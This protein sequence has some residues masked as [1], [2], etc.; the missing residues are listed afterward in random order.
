LGTAW[1]QVGAGLGMIL[2]QARGWGD[3][4]MILRWKLVPAPEYLMVTSMQADGR[5]RRS[6]SGAWYERSKRR[7][8]RYFRNHES[9]LVAEG[10]HRERTPSRVARERVP[11]DLCC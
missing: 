11:G 4:W 9:P 6:T 2:R 7:I 8:V 10:C 3:R 5:C 1:R